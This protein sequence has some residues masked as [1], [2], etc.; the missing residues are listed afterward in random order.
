MKHSVNAL[1]KAE[2]VVT[3]VLFS[4][5]VLSCTKDDE[6]ETDIPETVIHVDI[7]DDQIQ[8][9]VT[10]NF[11]PVYTMEPMTRGDLSA[12]GMTRL[13]VWL[14]EGTTEISAVHQTSSDVGFGSVSQNLNKTKT[15]TL[16][17]IAH[18]ATAACTLTDGII[19][20]PDDKPKESFFYTTNFSPATASTLNCAMAR[21]TGK[22]TLLTIDAVP[23]D[24]DH[25]R[26]VIKDTG[27]RFNVSGSPA[28][29]IDR[30][31][32]F[33]TI[34]RKT[35]GTTSFAFQILSTSDA[36]TNFNITATAYA[37][38]N[39]IVET[40]T[41]PAVPIRNNYRTTYSGA[42]FTTSA[43]SLTFTADDWND[44][45]VVNF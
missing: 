25:V 37:A 2:K 3:C 28:N 4:L 30:Q 35:D 32:D 18:K 26:F 31:V 13:D 21:I 1:T 42:F 6:P 15:Y 41:F 34:S 17:A 11:A 36:P 8:E 7:N 19:A 14:Y 27:T 43:M 45:D 10:I 33:A 40:K 20:W 9:H 44:Y 12:S 5:C 16:Y 23:D 29:I 22:F 38:D 39:S 24:V